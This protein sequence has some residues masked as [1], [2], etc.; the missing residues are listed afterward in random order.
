M[1][2]GIINGK[3]KKWFIGFGAD[4]CVIWG[5]LEKA[6]SDTSV[7]ASMQAYLL[8]RFDTVQLDAK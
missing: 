1:G 6:W 8:G 3:T 5:E 7:K 4:N 2:Y